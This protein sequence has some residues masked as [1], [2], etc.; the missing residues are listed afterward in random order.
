[1]CDLCAEAPAKHVAIVAKAFAN[2]ASCSAISSMA[3]ASLK[4]AEE[5]LH[6]VLVKFDLTLN[7][8]VTTLQLSSEVSIPCL[9]P[10]DYILTLHEKGFLNKLLGGS[11]ATS[12]LGCKSGFYTEL[13]L[14][15]KPSIA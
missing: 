4:D 14:A 9:L 11:I 13:F 3:K 6:K 8:K 1:M 10:S 2:E 5:A 12:A 7:V 15:F